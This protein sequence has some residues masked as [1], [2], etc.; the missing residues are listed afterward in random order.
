MNTAII[1]VRYLNMKGIFVL[2]SVNRL[3][4]ADLAPTKKVYID[5]VQKFYKFQSAM[6]WYECR[7]RKATGIL[8][9]VAYVSC[10]GCAYKKL[11]IIC[12]DHYG[13]K[14]HLQTCPN[15]TILCSRCGWQH[16]KCNGWRHNLDCDGCG[17]ERNLCASRPCAW[18]NQLVGTCK[19][20]T[21]LRW[22]VRAKFP[23]YNPNYKSAS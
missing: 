2:S 23:H 5:R 15:Y 12:D 18:C 4:A 20:P 8:Y 21:G 17:Y 11:C 1:I 13:R 9:D 22:C 16:C 10:L 6:R 14:S 19:C 3:Y 7:D